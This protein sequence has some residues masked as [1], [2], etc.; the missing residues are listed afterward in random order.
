MLKKGVQTVWV[1]VANSRAPR[2]VKVQKPKLGFKMEDFFRDIYLDPQM[3]DILEKFYEFAESTWLY[4]AMADFDGSQVGYDLICSKWLFFEWSRNR[5][6]EQ[7][8]MELNSEKTIFDSINWEEGWERWTD[9]FL[10]AEIL[11]VVRERIIRKRKKAEQGS[12]MQRGTTYTRDFDNFLIY[13][14]S[15]TPCHWT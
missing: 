13:D 14:V 5:R 2:F 12:W 11:S 6:P 15:G 7:A 1:D 9:H 8:L 4:E 3:S 10:P